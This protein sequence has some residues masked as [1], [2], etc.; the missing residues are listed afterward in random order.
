[1][2]LVKEVRR[3]ELA[4]GVKVGDLLVLEDTLSCDS[5]FCKL[6]D[7][8]QV[9]IKIIKIN[10]GH[11][12]QLTYEECAKY[13]VKKAK[14][15]VDSDNTTQVTK[16]PSERKLEPTKEECEKATQ[17]YR[18]HIANM[19]KEVFGNEYDIVLV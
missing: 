18:E 13:E 6:L 2:K 17:Q 12:K 3:Y 9:G 8:T 14:M 7:V 19:M 10:T 5:F 11:I 15:S 16:P 4:S 1:M